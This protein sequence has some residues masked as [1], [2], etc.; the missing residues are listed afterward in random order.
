MKNHLFFLA[1][2]LFFQLV[3]GQSTELNNYEYVIVP[4]EF[5]FQDSPNQYQINI[6]SRVLLKENGFEVFMDTEER[7]LELRGNSCK[8]LF[9][10]V[11]DTSSFLTISTVIRL[12][13]CYGNVLFESEEGKSKS[14]EFKKG[15]QEALR[16]AFN[17]LAAVNYNKQ[18][19]IISNTNQK[20]VENKSSNSSE[21]YPEKKAYKFQGEIY[22][23]VENENNGYTLLSKEG[24]VN[25]AELEKADRGSFLFNTNEVNGAAYFDAEGN[26]LVEYMDKDLNEVKNMTFKKVN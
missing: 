9:F 7:P 15:Y 17:T 16:Q 1:V 12:K 3:N 26:L 10:E 8:P 13:D 11:E 5:K 25:Y 6:L 14:K 23:L 2:A 19:S 20:P 4:M 21:L 24:K 22:W 18:N